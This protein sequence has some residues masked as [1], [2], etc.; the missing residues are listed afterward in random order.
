MFEEKNMAAI[1]NLI[2]IMLSLV[3]SE[4]GV[5]GRK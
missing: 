2:W 1:I 3:E 4:V 5:R